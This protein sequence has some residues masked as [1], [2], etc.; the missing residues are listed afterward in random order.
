A[1]NPGSPGGDL[2][3]CRRGEIVDLVG[4]ETL[5][6]ADQRPPRAPRPG[7]PLALE[8]RVQPRIRYET[9]IFGLA[10]V[11][12]AVEMTVHLGGR[13]DRPPARVLAP[14]RAL[15]A[16]LKL[17][18]DVLEARDQPIELDGRVGAA[19]CHRAAYPLPEGQPRLVEQPPGQGGIV[20]AP[21]RAVADGGAG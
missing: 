6:V 21:A 10:R 19:R 14:S 1:A 20:R 12:G 5:H 18:A 11:V 2:L 3:R 7:A 4:D 17:H 9:A 8:E 16:G 15:R 13:L